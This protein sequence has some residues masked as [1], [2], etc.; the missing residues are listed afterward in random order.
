MQFTSTIVAISAL[1]SLAAA[2]PTA[3]PVAEAVAEAEPAGAPADCYGANKYIYFYGAPESNYYSVSVPYQSWTPTYKS[4]SISRVYIPS[5]I[6]CS[7]KGVDSGKPHANPTLG[8]NG[9]L[10]PPQ[11]ITS[12]YCTCKH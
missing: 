10:G 9:Q 11:Q 1:L 3:A 4:L 8:A 7:F 2:A 12:V 5:G 6:T